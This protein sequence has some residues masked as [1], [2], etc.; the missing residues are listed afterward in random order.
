MFSRRSASFL[1]STTRE[2]KSFTYVPAGPSSQN[3]APTTSV[4]M[5]PYELAGETHE[6]SQSW[7]D[8]AAQ[9]GTDGSNL[10]SSSGES[11]SLPELHSRVGN[12]GL[13]RGWLGDRVGRDAQGLSRS[14]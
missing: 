7:R 14:R 5:P 4:D 13:P 11:V 9:G 2:Y 6:P 10:A 3:R 1:N 12:R 8:R